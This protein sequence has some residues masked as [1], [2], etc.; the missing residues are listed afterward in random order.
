M[1]H[2]DLTLLLLFAFIAVVSTSTITVDIQGN[3]IS[4][5]IRPNFAGFS[6][7]VPSAKSM[8]G[9][10]PAPPK[11][12]FVNLVKNL[13]VTPGQAG[14]I[15]R[16]GGNSA[17]ESW[18]NPDNNPKPSGITYD[19]TDVDLYSVDNCVK[20]FNGSWVPGVV[21]REPKNASWALNHVNAIDKYT[22]WSHVSAIEIGNECDLFGENGIRP[23]G[24]SFDDYMGDFKLY[25][26]AIYSE[27]KIPKKH[28]QGAT[29]CCKGDFEKGLPT[30]MDTDRAFLKTISYHRYPENHCN[31]NVATLEKLLEDASSVDQA[32]VQAPYI[33]D[34]AKLGLPYYI[35]ESNSVACGGQ[36][37]VSDILGAAL[38]GVDFMFNLAKVN[39]AGINFHGGPRSIYGPIDFDF[40]DP[41]VPDVRPL[42]YAMWVFATTTSHNSVIVDSKV[43]SDDSLVKVWTVKNQGKYQVIIIHKNYKGA[44]ASV[45]ITPPGTKRTQDAMLKVLEGKEGVYSKY[46]LTYA[47]QTFDN[48]KDGKPIGTSSPKSIR[49]SDG[50][51]NIVVEPSTIAVLEI[52]QE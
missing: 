39:A 23:S 28:I 44:S 17:D 15:L 24:Y 10:Y 40:S 46:G 2:T 41:N 6:I 30:Y 8:V 18:W 7:E 29:F 48:S 14:T 35:G 21:F 50:I 37:N 13:C 52:P 19:I 20:Q 36:H 26:D 4:N 38:W 47:S 25:A 3:T 32:A 5:P 9:E 51:Y 49:A 33:A 12:S 43:T 22:G 34:A 42:Y 16:I 31:G 27:T 1:F 45:S 11:E